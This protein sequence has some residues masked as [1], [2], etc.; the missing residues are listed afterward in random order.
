M[1]D[2]NMCITMTNISNLHSPG[3]FNGKWDLPIRLVK[4]QAVSPAFD[5]E[6]KTVNDLVTHFIHLAPL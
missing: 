2:L 5:F 1:P 6:L 3:L 4:L